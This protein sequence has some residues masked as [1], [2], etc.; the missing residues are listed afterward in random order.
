[1]DCRCIQQ[2]WAEELSQERKIRD[3]IDETEV[4]VRMKCGGD[5]CARGRSTL[6]DQRNV[7]R[8]RE[9]VCEWKESEK[10]ECVITTITVWFFLR[11]E[12][13]ARRAITAKA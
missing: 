1:M 4:V 8:E 10:G 6:R 3:N 9:S 13:R 11:E 12:M 5:D 2:Y 7:V